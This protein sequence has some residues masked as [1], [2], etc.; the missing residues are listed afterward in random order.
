MRIDVVA[1]RVGPL[2]R[3]G[4]IDAQ[5][6]PMASALAARRHRVTL[7]VRGAEAGTEPSAGVEVRVLPGAEDADLT[8]GIPAAAGALAAAWAADRPDVVHALSWT[9]GL[10]ALSGGRDI[11]LPLVQTFGEMARPDRPDFP[12]R[13][14]LEAAIARSSR[15]LV[16]QSKAAAEELR[17]RVPRT[18]VAMIPC[19]VD[20]ERFFPEP[21]SAER[22]AGPL[23]VVALCPLTGDYGADMAVRALRWAPEAELTIVGGPPPAQLPTD[24]AA[25]RLSEE[26]VR[27]R[28]SG[29]VSLTGAVPDAELA[30][31]L[32][33][34]DLV[35]CPATAEPCGAAAL[36]ALACGAPLLATEVD[37][38]ADVVAEHAC[39]ELVPPRRPEDFGRALHDLLDDPTR[40]AGYR[41][42]AAERAQGTYAWPRIAGSLEAA[43]QRVVQHSDRAA[44]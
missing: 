36:A 23:R 37:A 21:L 42:V 29:R 13:S 9:A 4:E 3:S 31:L 27:C 33:A 8:T 35:V 15:L 25:V 26:V 30:A 10:A 39:G 5:A 34:A 40:L 20:L 43:Y 7:W 14:R 22:A 18:A 44:G 12:A 19:G 38:L 6:V 24:P 1:D 28:V 32:R 41:I 17:Y 2:S 11:D 16:A